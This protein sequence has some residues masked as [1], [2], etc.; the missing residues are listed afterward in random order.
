MI[1][2]S[3]SG[4]HSFIGNT[5]KKVQNKPAFQGHFVM[6]RYDYQKVVENI[7]H[8]DPFK[9]FQFRNLLNR[10]KEHVTKR[11][12]ESVTVKVGY[13]YN[14]NDRTG[15]MHHFFSV[16]RNN[17]MVRGYSEISDSQKTADEII[18]VIDK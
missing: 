16:L 14:E 10:L 11:M 17:I 2:S 6:S 1:N 4:T 7:A 13:F 9:T 18:K 15:E 8:D 5:N 12:P 3:F